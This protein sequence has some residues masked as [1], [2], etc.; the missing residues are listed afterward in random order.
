MD[1]T[2]QLHKTLQPDEPHFFLVDAAF[3]RGFG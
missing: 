1:F 3:F 2:P